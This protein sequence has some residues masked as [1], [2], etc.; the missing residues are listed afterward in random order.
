MT[1]ETRLWGAVDVVRRTSDGWFD[2]TRM[3]KAVDE[4]RVFYEYSRSTRGAAY[5]SAL[6]SSLGAVKVVETSPATG[7]WVHPRL[8]LDVA[9]WLSPDFAVWL[10]G[11]VLDGLS[12]GA[13]PPPPALPALPQRL[14]HC[15]KVILN[16]TN[17]HHAVV[18]WLRGCHP[19]LH[20]IVP[21]LGEN[22]DTETKRI[23]SY[24]KGYTRGQPD[25]MIP[26][27][28][29]QHCGFAVELKHP[30]RPEM[31][32]AEAQTAVLE[33]L[34]AEGWRT[35][36]SNDYDEV[37]RELTEYLRPRKRRRTEPSQVLE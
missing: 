19:E 15:Q 6:A 16:E 26:A 24:A 35:L 13:A 12:K 1:L 28:T 10:D 22:Q 3:C 7:T 25:L 18:Q 5:V 32:V 23:D 33:H 14:Y 4:K 11:W 37:C 17:L 21:G 8:A 34:A 2:A 27:R 9:R 20:V 31:N 30:G 29:S 36:V